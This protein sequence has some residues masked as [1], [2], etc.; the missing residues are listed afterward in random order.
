MI[1]KQN[2]CSKQAPFGN[3]IIKEHLNPSHKHNETNYLPRFY[4]KNNKRTTINHITNRSSIHTVANEVRILTNTSLTNI[5]HHSYFVNPT[6]SPCHFIKSKP[7]YDIPSN[8]IN[9]YVHQ[10]MRNIKPSEIHCD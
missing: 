10:N 4:I 6:S 8:S 2:H 7:V 3:H 9:A 5:N 1:T